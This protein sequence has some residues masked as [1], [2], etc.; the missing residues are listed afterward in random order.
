[1]R[2]RRDRATDLCQD[3]AAD[4][5]QGRVTDLCQDR[6]ADQ[7][8]GDRREQEMQEIIAD[9]KA[10]TGRLITIIK[11]IGA[12]TAVMSA[13]TAAVQ[14]VSALREEMAGRT[15]DFGKITVRRKAQNKSGQG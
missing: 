11:M 6:A 10:K 14:V 5:C 4:P 13:V 12:A 15:I 3:R 1:M 9:L 8:Q 7:P 2:L